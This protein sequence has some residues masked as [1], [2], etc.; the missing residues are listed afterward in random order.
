VNPPEQMAT[1]LRLAE[2][3][4]CSVVAVVGSLWRAVAVWECV[5]CGGHWIPP[6]PVLSLN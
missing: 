1:T 6:Q 4:D 2:A 5:A 3:H